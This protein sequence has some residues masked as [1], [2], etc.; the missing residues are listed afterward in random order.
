MIQGDRV[1][2]LRDTDNVDQRRS[3]PDV[4]VAGQLGVITGWRGLEEVVIEFDGTSA[5]VPR[6]ALRVMTRKGR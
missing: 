5:V 2:V 4:V 6:A 1:V 3:E